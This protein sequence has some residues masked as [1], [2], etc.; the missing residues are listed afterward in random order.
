[1]RESKEYFRFEGVLLHLEKIWIRFF[2]YKG[3]KAIPWRQVAQNEM[4][5]AGS[6]SSRSQFP[7][8]QKS[9]SE[10]KFSRVSSKE[11]L[12]KSECSEKLVFW[13]ASLL[14]SKS[15]QKQGLR[16]EDLKAR[17]QKWVP[18]PESE[19]LESELLVSELLAKQV[20]QN[21]QLSL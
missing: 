10:I 8:F 20:T 15:S 1:M 18:L 16:S 12:L 19:L 11:S 2:L 14:E 7:K 3:L 5:E 4:L 9:V 13:K 21:L 17:N 6:L